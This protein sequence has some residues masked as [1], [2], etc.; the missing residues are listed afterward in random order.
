MKFIAVEVF[1]DRGVELLLDVGLSCSEGE[2]CRNSEEDD[3]LEPLFQDFEAFFSILACETSQSVLDIV[4]SFI[5]E[6]KGRLCQFIE[7]LLLRDNLLVAQSRPIRFHVLTAV[8][9][10]LDHCHSSFKL[11]WLQ[12]VLQLGQSGKSLLFQLVLIS[13]SCA[14]EQKVHQLLVV[15]LEILP[16]DIRHCFR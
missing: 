15:V 3:V 7:E 10:I 14:T 11:F 1:L 5:Y 12:F 8:V 2:D 13:H 16:N 6:F 9:F 4:P